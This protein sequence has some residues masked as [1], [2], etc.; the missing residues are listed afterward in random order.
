MTAYTTANT[1]ETKIGGI[2][3]KT[4]N[5]GTTTNEITITMPSLPTGATGFNI[6]RKGPGNPRYYY[7]ASTT[8]SSY[9]DD[10]STALTTSRTTPNNNRTFNTN[11]VIVTYPGATPAVPTG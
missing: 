2:G 4:V 7:L 8:G 6:Y 1:L 5:T 9:V 10:G 3:Y 11:K